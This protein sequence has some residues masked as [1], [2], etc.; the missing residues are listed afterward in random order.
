MVLDTSAVIAILTSDPSAS[1]LLTAI[2]GAPIR[3]IATASVVE[4]AM[5]LLALW[6]ETAEPQLDL[7]L[8]TI[9]AEV[10]PVGEEHML[11][12]RDAAVRFGK[13]RH[14]A[15]LNFGDCF[16]YALAVAAGEPLLFVGEDFGRTDVIVAAW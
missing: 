1:R 6:D 13:G 12:A 7:F 9:G 3:R 4:S 2:E 14:P 16:S 8:R 10:V 11:L 15:G 5:V